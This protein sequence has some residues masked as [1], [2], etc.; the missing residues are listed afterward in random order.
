MFGV[1]VRSGTPAI[2]LVLQI[3]GNVSQA[4]LNNDGLI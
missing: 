2:L 1:E 3:L 4:T